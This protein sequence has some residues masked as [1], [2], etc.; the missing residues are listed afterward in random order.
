MT[1]DRGPL[2]SSFVFT[3]RAGQ[4]ASS[5]PQKYV[6]ICKSLKTRQPRAEPGGPPLMSCGPAISMSARRRIYQATK[7]GVFVAWNCDVEYNVFRLDP[8]GKEIRIRRSYTLEG[9]SV[10]SIA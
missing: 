5:S 9:K 10:S 8:E 6:G 1:A 3:C 2:M 7:H 4:Q